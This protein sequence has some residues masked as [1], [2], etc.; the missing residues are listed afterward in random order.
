MLRHTLSFIFI[1]TSAL[2]TSAQEEQHT[3]TIATQELQEVVIQAPKVI[4][5]A[6]MDVFYPSVSAIEHSK[7]GLQMLKNLM[8][9]TLTVNDVMGQVTASG[10]SVQVRI[11]GREATIEQVQ[12][13]LP[14]TIKRV[15]WMDN[16][17]LRYKDA[18]AVLN[19]IVINPS[20][21]GSLM[22]QAMPALNCAWGQY[23]AGLK[24]NKGRSQFGFSANYKLTNKI[25]MHREYQEV[26]TYPDGHTLT[27]SESPTRGYMDNSF[28]G[29]Q[30]D[31]SYIKPDT[32]VLWVAVHGYK[33]WPQ[34]EF[35]EGRLSLSD[36]EET[37]LLHDY[38]AKKGFTPS[39]QV[40]FEQHFSH[41]Q[42]IAVDFNGSLYN[43]RT[44]RDYNERNETTL[45]PLTDVK[46]RIRD[47]NQAYGL[48]TNY[49]KKWKN[50]RLTAGI[51]YTANRN[52]SVY[53]NL[54]G[55]IFHQRQDKVYF[56]GEYYQRI[57]KVTLTAGFGAQYTDFHFKETEQGN[58]SWNLR[59]TFSATYSPNQSSQ[60]RLNFTSWQSAPSLAET[61]IAPQ[62]TD[63]FQW[64]VGN[65]NLKTSTSYMLTLRYNFNFPRVMGTFGVRA[66]TSPDAITPCLEWEGDR[67][68]KSYE[69]S[70]GLKN[71]SL[72]LSPQIE[73]VPDWLSLSGTLQYRAEQM[74][75]KG[76]RL[77]N[78]D[79]SGDVTAMLQHWNFTLTAQYQRAQ[80][81]LWGETISW[82]ESISILAL[83]YDW[84][85]WEFT[86][87]MICPFTKY[88]RGSKSLNKYN[89]NS[90]HV[91][92]DMSP[93][94]F[95]QVRYNIQ[96]GRQKRGAEKLVNADANVDKSSA[97][98]R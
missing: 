80:R 27:R 14:E 8:I 31:Y 77:Y 59:P 55:A 79:W 89:M 17:G 5:K 6:D 82:G 49:I 39:C 94:P 93:M 88:D 63:D 97:G 40:Y 92:L 70:R 35:Y 41:N 9:P 3:D 69:N 48:E 24:L 36:S 13:L 29:L 75:G 51:S 28:G 76:Y 10:Q 16:P 85:R 47:R 32:T 74:S 72:F 83:S 44:S 60:F 68:I 46:T 19:F 81:E 45:S 67:L 64:V 71:I 54:G 96:W 50:S 53:E 21:G 22:T 7:N 43:G 86:A 15:E 33:E 61:N 62:Q 30:M 56:F 37:I 12:N 57:K 25:S 98:G 90:T 42:L 73:I 11:N 26:F 58:S 66:F 95:I 65:P 87:G 52:R 84:R 18:N 20:T 38:N 4:R 23:S 2:L 34:A 1:T 78:H 91:R